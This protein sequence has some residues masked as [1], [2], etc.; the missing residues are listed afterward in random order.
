MRVVIYASTMIGLLKTCNSVGVMGNTHL[1]E[2]EH[3]VYVIN[4]HTCIYAGGTY[5][6]TYLRYFDSFVCSHCLRNDFLRENEMNMMK[7]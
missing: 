6:T 4:T 5:S 2:N 3:C 7:G 1:T